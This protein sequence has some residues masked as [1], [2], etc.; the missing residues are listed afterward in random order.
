[1]VYTTRDSPYGHLWTSSGGSTAPD[2]LSCAANWINGSGLAAGGDACGINGGGVAYDS[3]A[4]TSTSLPGA[5]MY[6]NEA[7]QITGTVAW[8]CGFVWTQ[9]ASTY[10]AAGPTVLSDFAAVLS[11]SQN[12]KYAVGYD[13]SLANGLLYDAGVQAVTKTI[14]GEA[15]AVNNHGWVGG[16]TDAGGSYFSGTAWLWDGSTVHDLNAELSIPGY[17]ICAV[18]GINDANQ[19]LVWGKSAANY[20]VIESFLLTPAL[21]GD[22]NLDGTVNINDL[23]KVLT[24][25]DK[26]GMAWADGDFN[27][28]GTVNIN[29]LSN[30]LTNYDRSL[31]ASAAGIVRRARAEHAG[32]AWRGGDRPLVP[33]VAE[34]PAGDVLT[35]R[36]VL[37]SSLG[38]SSGD[39]RRGLPRCAPP[40]LLSPKGRG[41]F[42]QRVILC[43]ETPFH[44]QGGQSHFC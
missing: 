6:V 43:H 29:D 8:G 32:S 16:D 31:G 36:I 18:W 5:G 1:M 30:V 3:V 42:C 20:D 11:I 34:T 19:V 13:T 25:Y 7:G 10:W 26:T 2:V 21:A 33:C 24:N 22:A 44:G 4:H 39:G 38:Q 28:D 17:T 12:G 14:P 23:S 37:P 15:R 27:G 40:C 41:L 35:Q 9:N